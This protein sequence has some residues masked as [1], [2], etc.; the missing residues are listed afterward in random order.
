MERL[1]PQEETI[2][3][4]IWKLG[5]CQIR[6]ILD[7]LPEAQPYTT[8]ASVA[9]NLKRKGYLQVS[10]RKNSYEYVPLIPESDY[11][12]EF[13]NSVVGHFFHNS[14]KEM[15]SF[16]AREQKISAAELQDILRLINDGD[17]E[18]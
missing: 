14:Y 10:R 16:F 18:S 1:T 3:R 7:A 2:M 17:D 15:V 8:I 9:N 11:K 13:V 5:T 6:D 4:C 12:Q